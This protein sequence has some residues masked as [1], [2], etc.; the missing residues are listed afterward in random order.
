ML[1]S[2]NQ[3]MGK[4]VGAVLTGIAAD[5]TALRRGRLDEEEMLDAKLDQILGKSLGELS[6]RALQ[7]LG[8]EAK[9]KI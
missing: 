3:A 6:D 7:N 2:A 9:K 5:I 4:N 1:K 8:F